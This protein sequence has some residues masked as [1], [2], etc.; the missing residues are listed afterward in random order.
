M[1]TLLLNGS[2]DPPAPIN[3]KAPTS[4]T[5]TIGEMRNFLTWRQAFEAAGLRE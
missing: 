4:V 1:T 3:A 5:G 2:V